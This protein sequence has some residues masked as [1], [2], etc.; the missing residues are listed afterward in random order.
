MLQRVSL[1]ITRRHT[2]HERCGIHLSSGCR[3]HVSSHL[4]RHSRLG[5]WLTWI[6]C[7]A[8]SHGMTTVDYMLLHSGMEALS[9]LSHHLHR[10]DPFVDDPLSWISTLA[11]LTISC[12]GGKPSANG[13]G[14][15]HGP[16]AVARRTMTT[17]K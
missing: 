4:G 17:V 12:A 15:K 3:D 2:T 16:N 6:V 9:P 5:A 13:A 14:T 1:G 11:L 10:S 8:G 7:H